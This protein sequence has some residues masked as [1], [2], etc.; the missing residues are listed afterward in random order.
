MAFGTSTK[1][2]DDLAL[3]QAAQ[4]L[5]MYKQAEAAD[6]QRKRDAELEE[7]RRLEAERKAAEAAEEARHRHEAAK[8]AAEEARWAALIAEVDFIEDPARLD[9]I[10]SRY[11]TGDMPRQVQ[12]KEHFNRALSLHLEDRHKIDFA[13]LPFDGKVMFLPVYLGLLVG[14]DYPRFDFERSEPGSQTYVYVTR[15]GPADA[16][17]WNQ[18]LS[19]INRYL[20]GSWKATELDGTSIKLWRLP[21]LPAVVPLTPS[22]FRRGEIFFG[23]DLATGQPYYVPLAKM[24]HTL[25]GGQSGVGKSVML[26]QCLRSML[27]NLDLI[28]ELILVDLKRVELGRYDGL[29]PKITVV[30]TYEELPALVERVLANM[31]QRL[32]DLEKRRE[33][34]VK[35]GFIILVIDEYASIEQQVVNGKDETA[36]K[37]A[38]TANLV[39]LSQLGRAAGIRLWA[40][41]QKPTLDNMDSSFRTNLQ[42]VACFYMP[43]KTNATQMFGDLEGL[44][45]DPTNLNRGEFI[46]QD[47]GQ[48]R[49]VHLRAAMCDEHDVEGLKGCVPPAHRQ[50]QPGDSHG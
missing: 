9:N 13:G 49:T 32:E 7:K 37:K 38:L 6:A 15:H 5:H 8:A 35:S 22:L 44:P 28:D 10:L 43:A 25:V 23:F 29:S 3:A 20:G 45:A 4:A 26:N 19:R 12:T 2:L 11:K 50:R 41:L 16:A 1:K 18:S 21:E 46:F 30:R 48:N 14:K 47:D 27:F 31:Y 33:L 40:Q 42:S 39:K 24:T 17:S 34:S 36:A